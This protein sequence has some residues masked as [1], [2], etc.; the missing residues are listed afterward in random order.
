[1]NRLHGDHTASSILSGCVIAVVL[2]SHDTNSPCTILV[3][4]WACDW[5][6]LRTIEFWGVNTSAEW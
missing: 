4:G 2:V 1:M 6:S 5:Y 3:K